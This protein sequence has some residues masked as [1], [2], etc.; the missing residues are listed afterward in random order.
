MLAQCGTSIL[1]PFMRP[2]Q[3]M[4]GL[5]EKDTYKVPLSASMHLSIH[6][7]PVDSSQTVQRCWSLML[8]QLC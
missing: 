4:K 1:V 2:C 6:T 3:Y 8:P 5:D 7:L